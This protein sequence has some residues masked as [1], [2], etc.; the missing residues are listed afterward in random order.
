LLDD[1]RIR[2]RSRIREAQ[3]HVDT[4]NPDSDLGNWK[5][6]RFSKL[7]GFLRKDPDLDP[8]PGLYKVI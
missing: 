5:K 2:I 3:K 6:L 1:R 4:V 8:K 7:F